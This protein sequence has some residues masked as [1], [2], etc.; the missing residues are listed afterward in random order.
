MILEKREKSIKTVIQNIIKDNFTQHIIVDRNQEIVLEKYIADDT[1]H[2][3]KNQ[4]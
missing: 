1:E 2:I 4:R 3:H